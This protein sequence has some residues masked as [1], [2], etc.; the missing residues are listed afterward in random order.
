MVGC[1]G[2]EGGCVGLV[3]PESMP[4]RDQQMPLSLC[5]IHEEDLVCQGRLAVLNFSLPLLPSAP[6]RS[7]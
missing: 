1:V 7:S 6:V 2:G 4:S 3:V 5:D